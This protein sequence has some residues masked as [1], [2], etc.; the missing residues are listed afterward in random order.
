MLSILNVRLCENSVPVLMRWL[1]IFSFE[2]ATQDKRWYE[3]S[4][5][6]KIGHNLL[7]FE[8]IIVFYFLYCCCYYFRYYYWSHSFQHVF[9]REKGGTVQIQQHHL[10][11]CPLTIFSK[12]EIYYISV[13]VNIRSLY[14]IVNLI[15]FQCYY[16]NVRGCPHL[17]PQVVQTT[18]VP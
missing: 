4:H 14:P 12:S 13:Y 16:W 15:I 17:F 11:Y 10:V 8:I 5:S 9:P 1:I 2:R 18:D 7:P 6:D 3:R